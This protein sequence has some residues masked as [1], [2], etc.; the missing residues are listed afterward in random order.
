MRT[1]LVGTVSTTLMGCSCLGPPQA[2][3]DWC[4]SKACFEQSANRASAEML[5][6]PFTP[7]TATTPRSK[8]AAKLAKSTP[9]QRGS[10]AGATDEKGHSQTAL[11]SDAPAPDQDPVLIKAKS[12]IAAKMEDPASAEFADM[13]RATRK[14][15]LGQPVDTICGHVKGK[16][17]SGE[18]TGEKP[19]LYLVKED[20]A[21]VVDGDAESVAAIAYRNICTTADARGKDVRQRRKPQ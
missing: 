20:E 7:N 3:V 14:N 15:T 13:K 6:A 2:S 8:P 11:K 16:K 1:L 4:P 19:F 18:D 21:Y 12:T 9:E 5:P 17:A 10:R